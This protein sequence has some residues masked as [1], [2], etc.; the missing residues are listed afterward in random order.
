MRRK[1][2]V[3]QKFGSRVRKLRLQR[4]YS[5]DA[6][7]SICGLDRTYVGGIERGERN[8]SL[9]N[10]EILAKAFDLSLADLL[11]GV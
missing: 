10:I 2:D 4:S 1:D 3:L 9:R 11:E 8:I 7:A 6:F 5:Q